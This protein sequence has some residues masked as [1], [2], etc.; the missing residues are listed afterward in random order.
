PDPMIPP[1][2]HFYLAGDLSSLPAVASILQ[3][4]PED[5]R[6][7][8]MVRV[9]DK[10]DI[11]DLNRPEG[12]ELKWFVSP[13]DEIGELVDAFQ[14][15]SLPSS[16]V[17]YWIGGEHSLVVALRKHLVTERAV[18]KDH[19]YALPYWRYRFS[20]ETYHDTRDQV[21]AE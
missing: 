14:A 2:K 10:A 16:D 20:E 1:V 4:L 7:A 15:L 8:A 19:L 3:H 11:R 6:G 18:A 9:D 12:M 17:H 5:V 13:P 21:M